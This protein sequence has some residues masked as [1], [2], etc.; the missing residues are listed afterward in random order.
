M[1]ARYADYEGRSVYFPFSENFE[2]FCS[3]GNKYVGF[4][5]ICTVTE[6]SCI[7]N[8]EEFKPGMA[9]A[10][11]IN[12]TD[13]PIQFAQQGA[14][15]SHSVI[16]LPRQ[17]VIFTYSNLTKKERA[18]EWNSGNHHG[19]VYLMKDNLTKYEPLYDQISYYWVAFFNGRQRTLLFTKDLS[20]ATVAKE[21]YE[22]ECIEQQVELK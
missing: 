13:L 9:T 4:Y 3:T 1:C 14:S 7:I 22:M 20:V 5:V 6:S 2:E 12:D 18:I 15:S 19:I 8:I 16:L 17:Q 10:L 11:L 21:A